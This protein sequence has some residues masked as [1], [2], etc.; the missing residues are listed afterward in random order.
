MLTFGASRSC[1]TKTAVKP[2]SLRQTNVYRKS[3]AS[4]GPSVWKGLGSNAE[5]AP[6]D[7]F[8]AGTTRALAD[9]KLCLTG[10]HGEERT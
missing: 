10:P 2:Q 9:T 7:G 4:R 3:L 8:Q 1:W 5:F 6:S